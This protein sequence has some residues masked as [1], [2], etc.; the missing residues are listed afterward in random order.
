MMSWLK[1]HQWV[2]DSDNSATEIVSF[3]AFLAMPGCVIGAV[4]ERLFFN[5]TFNGA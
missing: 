1:Q 3:L 4:I 5:D 2:Q